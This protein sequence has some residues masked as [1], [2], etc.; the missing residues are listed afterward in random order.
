MYRQGTRWGIDAG[1]HR[2]VINSQ[3][4]TNLSARSHTSCTVFLVMF[5]DRQVTVLQRLEVA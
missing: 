4:L 5:A 3:E 2:R 1:V